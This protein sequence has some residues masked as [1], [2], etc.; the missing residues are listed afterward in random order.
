MAI[1]CAVAIDLDDDEKRVLT[2]LARKHGAPQAI[3]KWARIVL[4]AADCCEHP[5]P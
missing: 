3:V 5:G 4:A 2:A 1:G